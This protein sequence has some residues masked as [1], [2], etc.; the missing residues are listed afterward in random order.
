MLDGKDYSRLI[1]PESNF[2]T[3]IADSTWLSQD[4][5]SCLQIT[6]MIEQATKTLPFRS[7]LINCSWLWCGCVYVA[8]VPGMRREGGGGTQWEGSFTLNDTMRGERR[9][10][11]K[12]CPPR[13]R[14][15][16]VLRLTEP[17]G[18][19]FSFKTTRIRLRDCFFRAL[20]RWGLGSSANITKAYCGNLSFAFLHNFVEVPAR[21]WRFWYPL[22]R[23]ILELLTSSN[24][25]IA[26]RENFDG[27]ASHLHRWL[28]GRGLFFIMFY[29]QFGIALV[30]LLVDARF[31]CPFWGTSVIIH[32]NW[33]ATVL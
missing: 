30:C 16:F 8:L 5:I 3:R 17:T 20:R 14:L 7:H 18:S 27:L 12:D 25:F 6:I 19:A 28:E 26:A 4:K 10:I 29:S 33:Q 23:A 2:H 1:D 22:D 31:L 24:I 13:P 11:W 9:N 21:S 32:G 15:P